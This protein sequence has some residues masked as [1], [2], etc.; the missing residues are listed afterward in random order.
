MEELTRLIDEISLRM[1]LLKAAEE[2]NT[3]LDDLTDREVLI[4]ELLNE[5]GKLSVSEITAAFSKV[6]A[7]TISVTIT[8]LWRGKGL[9]EKAIDPGNQ[10]VTTVA[11]SAKGEE[12]VAA[13][14]RGRAEP[15]RTL[16]RAL[17][18]ES[19]DH[20]LLKSI[21]SRAIEHFDQQLG[22]AR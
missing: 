9:V 11:L 6:A 5:R 4:L 22:L 15:Y 3:P 10:R 14:K 19:E 8:K 20:D 13:I 18:M 2:A 21:I 12:A 1:R 16:I 7:S 17:A